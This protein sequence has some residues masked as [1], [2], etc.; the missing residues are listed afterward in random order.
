MKACPICSSHQA[1]LFDDSRSPRLLICAECRHLFW[2]RRPTPDELDRF[3]RS[4]YTA[5]HQQDEI[6][7][8]HREY[9]RGHVAELVA[10][11]G[12]DMAATTFA[13]FGCSFPV[14]LE[15]AQKSGVGR[16][17]GIDLDP[18]S[19]RYGAERGIPMLTPNAFFRTVRA[20]S[21]DVIRFSHVLEHLIDPVAT[22]AGAVEK[23]A[24]GGLLYITQPSFP[25]FKPGRTD[26]HV[27]DS[28]YPTHLHFFS[29]ISLRRMLDRF[30]LRVLKFFTV[31]EHD[32]TFA[33]CQ[34]LLDLPYAEK[35]LAPWNILGEPVRGVR[36]NYPTY[37]GQNSGLYAIKTEA[38]PE[39]RPAHARLAGLL[40]RAWGK[41]FAGPTAV[42]A[43]K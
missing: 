8:G 31:G 14:L 3:Y 27:K 43:A 37:S 9:Y 10:L 15:E 30:P 33:G 39:R 20:N 24:P 6:Q 13:D 40:A 41:V 28:V 21:L 29:P 18:A 12:K 36:A 7:A 34:H 32:E 11:V 19:Q 22:V 23:L 42:S 17:L 35:H 25:V 1:T 4:D 16:L 5:T 26:Y 2:D 38:S